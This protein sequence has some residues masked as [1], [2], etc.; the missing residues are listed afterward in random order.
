LRVIYRVHLGNSEH[1]ISRGIGGIVS[2]KCAARRPNRSKAIPAGEA[3][4]RTSRGNNGCALERTHIIISVRRRRSWPSSLAIG[5]HSVAAGD[6]QLPLHGSSRV[7]NRRLLLAERR[8]TSQPDG[9]SLLS[10]RWLDWTAPRSASQ[11]LG[12]LAGRR[13]RHQCARI[14]S[15]FR[16]EERV[17]SRI[18]P[19]R[20]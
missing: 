6:A 16:V 4:S 15:Q 13:H 18:C 10:R 14:G 8:Q 9:L 5:T 2:D 7:T 3:V 20:R 12:S 19:R 17:D 11:G 1:A